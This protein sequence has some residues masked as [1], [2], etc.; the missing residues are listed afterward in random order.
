[1][2]SSSWAIYGLLSLL[3]ITCNWL[4]AICVSNLQ[5]GLQ[6]F[7][8]ALCFAY[9]F[10]AHGLDALRHDVRFVEQKSYV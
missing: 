2:G 7:S 5:D 8:G 4:T 3:C 9:P 6:P 10:G 1:M